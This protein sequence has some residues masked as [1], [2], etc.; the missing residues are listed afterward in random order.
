MNETAQILALPKPEKK[1]GVI[2]IERNIAVHDGLPP[3]YEILRR[4]EIS[5]SIFVAGAKTSKQ[6]A[7]AAYKYGKRNGKKFVARREKNGRRIWR[8]A[9]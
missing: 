2:T 6:L 1:E 5:D 8:V 4:M 3:K 7:D 9:S